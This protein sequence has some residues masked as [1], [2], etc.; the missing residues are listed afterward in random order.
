MTTRYIDDAYT[1]Y[2]V[3]TRF[4]TGNATDADAVLPYRVYEEETTTPILTGN[5]ALLDSANTAG[6]YSEQITLS[7]ANGFEVGKCYCVHI[8]GTVN[9]VVG[10]VVREFVV[11]ATPV[12]QT[13]DSYAI[14]NSGTHGNA[15]LKTL[16]DAIEAQTDDIGAAGAGLNAVPW[17][18][19]WDAEVQS[20]VA[21]ALTAYGVSTYAGGAAVP[22]D[23]MT[24]TAAYDSAK[25]AASQAS[26][27]A[28]N[29]LST[30]DAKAAA[31]DALDDCGITAADGVDR[32]AGHDLSD[33]GTGG[34]LI[35]G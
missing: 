8:A 2:A 6:F 31:I 22:G 20:E 23:P 5:M 11:R 27:N 3:S 10:A 1:F 28:L 18:A 34:Y 15:A 4:D 17:N 12:A 7:A 21:D 24:L 16:I 14:V 19:A 35:G 29:D 30:A 25:T 13:G 26:V 33:G 32:I 9:S